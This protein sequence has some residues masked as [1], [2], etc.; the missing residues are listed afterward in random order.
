MAC[1]YT[2]KTR[3]SNICS[4]AIASPNE[5]PDPNDGIICKQEINNESLR[6]L[7]LAWHHTDV[8]CSRHTL[9]LIFT[10]ESETT[11]AFLL[12]LGTLQPFL[13]MH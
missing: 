7:H 9:Q 12:T 11:A 1:V 13:L 3:H 8:G 10:A 5:Y 4:Q 6:T 2:H